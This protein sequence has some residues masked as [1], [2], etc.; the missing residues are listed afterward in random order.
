MDPIVEISVGKLRGTITKD[1]NDEQVYAFLGIPYAKAP[2]GN[3]RFKVS[4]ENFLSFVN[5]NVNLIDNV[6]HLIS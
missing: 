3:L 1:D 4:S 6:W 5:I 2:V